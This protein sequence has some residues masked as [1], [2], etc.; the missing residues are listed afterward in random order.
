MPVLAALIPALEPIA[1][2]VVGAVSGSGS[3]GCANQTPTDT[4][5]LVISRLSSTERSQLAAWL[6]KWGYSQYANLSNPERVAW[7]FAGGSDCK[8]TTAAAQDGPQLWA[9]FVSKYGAAAAPIWSVPDDPRTTAGGGSIFSNQPIGSTGATIPPVVFDPVK[10]VTPATPA[11]PSDDFWSKLGDIFGKITGPNPAL[12]P[13]SSAPNASSVYW[14]PGPTTGQ[15]PAA[16]SSNT[17][18]LLIGGAALLVV[19]LLVVLMGR[20]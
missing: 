17:Q 5:A 6:N 20:K 16:S 18:L 10:G 7:A 12:A 8:T 3:K 1:K 13:A 14:S 11:Q 15:A 9:S 4:A 2:A 19:V